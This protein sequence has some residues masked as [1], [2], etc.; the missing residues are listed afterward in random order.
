MYK[1]LT[2]FAIAALLASTTLH[3]QNGGI[4]RYK[5]HDAQG[6]SHFSDSLSTDAMKA[7]YDLVND[8]GMVIRHVPRQLTADERATA[9]KLAAVEAAKRRA[10][11]AIASSEAQMLSAYPTEEMYKISLQQ[12][13]ETIDQ[14]IHTTQ[15]NLR[16][17]EK[18]LTELLA[19]AAEYEAAKKAMPP[20][21]ITSVAKQR[22]VVTSQRDTL[23]RQQALHD[24]TVKLQVTQLARYRALA[25]AQAKDAE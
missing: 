14:K 10:A 6:L 12:T 13:M 1:S 18:T 5:W 7:G 15:L 9:N 23:H 21:M 19:R 3:A 22:E 20:F 8:S 4:I 25:A 16:S 24:Q 17:Q 2:A 11:Q